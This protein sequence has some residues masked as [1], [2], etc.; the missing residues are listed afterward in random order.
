MISA[1]L[2]SSARSLLEADDA[3][4]ILS[5]YCADV[6]E[7]VPNLVLAWAWFGDPATNVVQPQVIAGPASE[8]AANLCIVR[9]RLT[10]MGPAYKAIAGERVDSY[11]ISPLSLFGPWR[12]AVSTYAI[13]SVLAMPLKST[14][15]EQR[16]VLVLYAHPENYF[17]HV[18]E[19]VFYALS[20][21]FSAVLSRSAKQ[22]ALRKAAFFDKLTGLL[23][24]HAA[25]GLAR[26]MER[27][28]PDS[29][30]SALI[31][32]DLDH[33]KSVNDTYGHDTGDVV[34][35]NVGRLLKEHVRM[36]D[37]TLR[38]GGGRVPGRVAWHWNSG[39]LAHRGKPESE[40]SSRAALVLRWTTAMCH[41]QHWSGQP[42]R[43]RNVQ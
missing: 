7:K 40:D 21:L 12:D 34:L 33:F 6:T 1:T 37:A 23:N 16:G 10:E 41:C 27:T 43:G 32:F 28:G 2:L 11:G 3:C 14:V 42:L 36:A 8:Y 18:G 38:W 5:R 13:R 31:L 17:K 19:D 15:D 9:N 24:R 20:D 29:P 39:R 26:R 25:P 4:E 22:E 30:E 35:S